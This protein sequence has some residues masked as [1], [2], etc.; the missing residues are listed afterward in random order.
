[1]VS[2]KFKIYNQIT[3]FRSFATYLMSL[4]RHLSF[5]NDKE[6]LLS[7]LETFLEYGDRNA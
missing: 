6:F 4:E 1:M 2:D 5:E 7:A 3:A